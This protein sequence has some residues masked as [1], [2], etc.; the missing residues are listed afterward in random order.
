MALEVY[1]RRVQCACDDG[2]LAGDRTRVLANPLARPATVQRSR[3]GGARARELYRKVFAGARAIIGDIAIICWHNSSKNPPQ[4]CVSAPRGR[5]RALRCAR[6]CGPGLWAGAADQMHQSTFRLLAAAW[7]CCCFLTLGAQTSARVAQ[8]GPAERATHAADSDSQLVSNKS[9][10]SGYLPLLFIDDA[11]FESTHGGMALRVQ[12][13]TVGPVVL[14]ADKGWESMGIG[15]YNHA[16][17]FGPTDYRIYY[18]C[19]EYD[20]HSIPGKATNQQRLCLARSVD[21]VVWTKPP[22]DGPAA[23]CGVV[24]GAYM[25]GSNVMAWCSMVSVFE[26]LNP[27]TQPAGRYKMLC[28]KQ[29]YESPDGLLWTR[30]SNDTRPAITHADD[31]QDSGWFDPAVGKYVIY[32]RRDL[33]IPGRT[34]SDKFMSGPN[35]CRL[36][37]R[38]ETTSLTDWEQGNRDGCPAVFGPDAED[39]AGIDLYT[40]GFAPYEGV[41]LFFPAAMYGFGPNFPWGYGNDGLLD[42]RFAASRDGKLI[43]YV[44]GAGNAREPWFELGPNRCGAHASAPDSYRG[45]WCDPSDPAQLSRTDP[46]TTTNYMTGGLMES[47]TGEEVYLYVGSP[48]TIGHGEIFTEPP[49]YPGL[50]KD[51]PPLRPPLSPPAGGISLLR[52]RKHGFVAAEG[53][54]RPRLPLTNT[55]G[56]RGTDYPSA[57]GPSE[58]YPGFKTVALDLPTNCHGQL[59]LA[60]NAKTSVAGFVQ[61]GLIFP[62]NSASYSQYRLCDSDPLRGNFQAA[63]AS[64]GGGSTRTLPTGRPGGDRVQLEVILVAAK[65]FS[66]QF[67]CVA[68]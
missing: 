53:P 16:M 39:P 3:G 25:A 68:V 14:A 49:I 37:G 22:C 5:S 60:V 67:K 38:C 32:V 2:A 20:N 56:C 12:P 34:C 63:T 66:L 52:V 13:P 48:N 51:L 47:P 6:V 62:P 54:S 23:G 41:Q 65:L 61:I 27:D 50:P 28:N 42:I 59:V 9:N 36:I 1:A 64:W 40:S 8:E 35:T 24:G 45:G 17:K 33:D 44:P 58:L 55:T 15:G 11:L 18:N 57:A 7:G 19:M 43:R 31:T 30:M 4:R 26:D 21:G 46:H 29:A 10:S